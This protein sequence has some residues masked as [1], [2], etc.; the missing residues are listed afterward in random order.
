MVGFLLFM[1]SL[2]TI[3]IADYLQQAFEQ[4]KK[5]S[6][7]C[8]SHYEDLV[9]ECKKDQVTLKWVFTLNE[10]FKKFFESK[11]YI[12]SAPYEE[13]EFDVPT[14]KGRIGRIRA[15]IIIDEKRNLKLAINNYGCAKYMG[16]VYFDKYL[17][18]CVGLNN[19][20]SDNGL[21]ELINICKKVAFNDGIG[22]AKKEKIEKLI[23]Q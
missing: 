6:R 14:E 19:D 4:E 17:S 3:L 8:E 22:K 16:I 11:D 18:N 10:R 5:F 2:A 1:S 23:N 15:Q 12:S 21:T 7:F 20:G 9:E 13:F